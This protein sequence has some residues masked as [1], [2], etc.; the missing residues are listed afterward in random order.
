MGM[1]S[2][3]KPLDLNAPSKIVLLTFY[4]LKVNMNWPLLLE[5]FSEFGVI[6]K[7]N[8]AFDA[9]GCYEA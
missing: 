1:E 6:N 5:T 9:L 2:T 3:K 7:V 4:N 8:S